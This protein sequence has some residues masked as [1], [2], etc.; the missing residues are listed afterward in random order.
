VAK[1]PTLPTGLAEIR[2]MLPPRSRR[3]RRLAGRLHAARQCA[4]HAIFPLPLCDGRSTSF[5]PVTCWSISRMADRGRAARLGA[6]AKAGWRAAIAVPDFGQDRRELCRRRQ[7]P[8]EG[9]VMGGQT[10]PTISTRRCSTRSSL[11]R[12]LAGAGLMLIR[13]WESES[14]TIAHR[15]RSRS[16]WSGTKPHQPEIGVSAVMSVPRLGFMDTCS[17]CFEALPP[18]KREAPPLHGRLLGQCLERT[19]EEA[20]AR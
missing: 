6:R 18:L 14:R 10:A 4:W 3:R 13:R 12:A 15:C 11:K 17:A 5:A 20:L 9:Y 8:T 1:L 16:I 7:Q 2:A 19:I